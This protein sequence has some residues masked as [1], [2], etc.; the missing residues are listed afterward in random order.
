MVMGAAIGNR[1]ATARRSEPRPCGCADD[2]HLEEFLM[3]ASSTP[4]G[5]GSVAEQASDEFLTA[6]TVF[7]APYREGKG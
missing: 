4:E 3:T 7:L 5:P 1:S 6:L 2:N